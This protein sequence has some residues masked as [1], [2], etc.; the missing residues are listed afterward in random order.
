MREQSP[1][2]WADRFL[3]WYCKPELLETIQGDVYELF[4]REK[5]SSK[6]RRKFIWNVLRFF[7]W[8]NIKRTRSS[9]PNRFDML[10]HYFKLGFRNLLNNRNHAIINVTGLAVAIAAVILIALYVQYEL[11][12]DS[13][14]A[15]VPN[16]YR[17]VNINKDDNT[18]G[19]AKITGMLGPASSEIRSVKSFVRITWAASPMFG[20]NDI[21]AFEPNGL[22]A[23]ANFLEMFNYRIVEGSPAT[24]FSSPNSVVLTP[25]LVKKYFG[26]ESALGKTITINNH[27]Q[28]TVS[29]VIEAVQPNTHFTFTFLFPMEADKSDWLVWDRQ[30]YYTFLQLDDNADIAQV[31][32]DLDVIYAKN[33]PADKLN[34]H[35]RLQPLT[36]IHLHS[37]LTREMGGNGNLKTVY[38]YI[39]IALLVLIIACINY[40][41]IFTAKAG[42]R[43]KEIGMRKVSGA[44]RSELIRQFLSESFVLTFIAA[45]AGVA[46]SLATLPYFRY[47]IGIPLSANNIL[48]ATF[49]GLFA[50]G[51][52]VVALLAGG[53]PAF[54]L[55]AMKP[56][57]LQRGTSG[58]TRN[59]W[60][61]GLVLVQFTIS[62]FM[63]TALFG[64]SGQIT[65]MENKSLGFAKDNIIILQIRDRA[66]VKSRQAVIEKLKSNPHVTNVS[67]SGTTLG[68]NDWGMPVQPEGVDRDKMPE[69]RIMVVDE[70]FVD[71]YKFKIIE[72]RNF[73]SAFP[74]DSANS[75]LVNAT[76]A[77]EFGWGNNILG[78][79]IVIP[80]ANNKTA[81]VVGVV[82]DF[83]FRSLHSEIIPLVMFMQPSW[84]GSVSIRLDGQ[85][86]KETIDDIADI[87]QTFEPQFPFAYGYFDQALDRLYQADRNTSRLVTWSGVL[88]VILACIGLFS[89]TAYQA[90][91]R[92][93]EFGIRKVLGASVESIV[94]IQLKA[95]TIVAIVGSLT[96]CVFAWYII[97][98]WLT[99]FAYRTSIQPSWF[100]LSIVLSVFVAMAT[101]IYQSLRSAMVNPVQS[102]KSNQ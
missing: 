47:A 81:V 24:M 87:W 57:A 69:T 64:V 5:D 74:A 15:K 54:Y 48:D 38:I 8:K 65:Y 100:L 75:V 101:S 14:L 50:A 44:K 52:F 89:L 30:Q 60:R 78:R 93:R 91:R 45:A 33:I 2:R 66:T 92:S 39:S 80:A 67:F 51:L 10:Q 12:Y 84:D 23:D 83:H 99:G 28:V 77:R 86:N 71:T 88:A 22:Y 70:N 32:K 79:R 27:A 18:R 76:A 61:E 58:A 36:S 6:A 25:N 72:G 26:D 46:L 16:V 37:A 96:A 73:S 29:G 43:L 11:T 42:E 40:I 98:K 20:V 9:S 95:Y 94:A 35:A 97:E 13:K 34:Y 90:T 85:A 3:Q 53:Y 68:G 41:N 63:I 4:Y 62:A 7:R 17:V 21:K 59:R 102:I 82:D 56:V 19:L 49:I 55:S 1:P 31:E